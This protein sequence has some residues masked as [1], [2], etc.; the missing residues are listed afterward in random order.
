[1]WRILVVDDEPD[2]RQIVSATLKTVYEVFEAHDGLDALEKIERVEPDFVVMDVMMPNMDGFDA[3]AAIRKSPKFHDLP[4][5]FLTALSDKDNIRKGYGVGANLYL[6]KP[7][8]PSRL[9]KNVEVHFQTQQPARRPKRYT[10]EELKAAERQGRVPI[11]PGSMEYDIG[12]AETK[13][14]GVPTMPGR[15]PSTADIRKMSAPT[16]TAGVHAAPAVPPAP[17]PPDRI[18]RILVVDDDPHILELIRLTVEGMVEFTFA[19]DG[20]SAIEKLVRYQPDIMIIDVMLPKISGYKLLESIRSNAAFVTLPILICSAKGTDR[21]IQFARRMGANDYLVKPFQ[22][23]DL[24]GKIREIMKSPGF[25]I[26][27]KTMP[28]QAITSMEAP[29]DTQAF[30]ADE[31][32]RKMD[33]TLG[34]RGGGDSSRAIGDF[35]KKEGDRGA[36]ERHGEEEGGE[37]KRTRRLF[38]FGRKDDD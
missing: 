11:A 20:I 5:M 3:C 23:Q 37:K 25:R 18:P 31:E 34:R 27:P 17:M 13:H 7:F 22:P 16:P 26:R 9:L 36:F 21:D 14:D 29:P 1:M 30:A 32:V 6:T 4:V 28:I 24:V 12:N 15:V 35:L 2:V 19:A 38:G 8:D 33:D 10:F